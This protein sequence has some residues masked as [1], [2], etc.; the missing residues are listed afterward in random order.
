[1]RVRPSVPQIAEPPVVLDKYNICPLHNNPFK[2]ITTYSGHIVSAAEF[3]KMKSHL[4]KLEQII[5]V[6]KKVDC[7]FSS[8]LKQKLNE[9][10]S[11]HGKYSVHVLCE[12]LNVPRGT[13]Y[14]HIFRNK[15]KQYQPPN[16]S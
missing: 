1:M 6:F 9:L 11:L 3:I 13:S 4:Q 2:T 16:S 12:A 14:N 5:E 7:S 15:K 10:E 8:P